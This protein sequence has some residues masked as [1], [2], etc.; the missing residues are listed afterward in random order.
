M[1]LFNP[2]RTLRLAFNVVL[3]LLQTFNPGWTAHNSSIPPKAAATTSGSQKGTCAL[4][5][6][7]N[8][9]WDEERREAKRTAHQTIATP[10][11]CPQTPRIVQGQL[12]RKALGV[13]Q[14]KRKPTTALAPQP[15]P[16]C[17]LNALP[18]GVQPLGSQQIMGR[19]EQE[20]SKRFFCV[21]VR[22]CIILFSL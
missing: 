13:G 20:K 22:P 3:E 14:S 16:L 18:V 19:G 2:G 11:H 10:P 9:L 8:P 1:S 6:I 15:P 4:R 21:C 7:D 17:W 5:P 12:I